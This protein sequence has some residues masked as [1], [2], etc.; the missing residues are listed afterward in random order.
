M[1]KLLHE[2]RH[3]ALKHVSA[4]QAVHLQP[5]DRGYE[6]ANV[7]GTRPDGTW[8]KLPGGTREAW[9]NRKLYRSDGSPLLRKTYNDPHVRT[10]KRGKV[11][12]MGTVGDWLDLMG[13]TLEDAQL[14]AQDVRQ[15]PEFKELLDMGVED[16]TSPL[17]TKNGTINLVA[18]VHP[19]LETRRTAHHPADESDTDDALASRMR[20]KVLA[21]GTVRTVAGWGDGH[22]G[23][24]NVPHPLTIETH[25]HL[26]GR[27]RVEGSMRGALATLIPHYR[28]WMKSEFLRLVNKQ[29]AEEDGR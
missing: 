7:N 18:F 12:I 20:R 24:G 1:L 27:E 5:G 9:R 14:A 13:A 17:D 11:Q 22:G 23:R 16:H 28:R 19:P 25:P 26:T 6:T 21:N 4:M 3:N 8:G 29:Q 15:S 10:L 2:L